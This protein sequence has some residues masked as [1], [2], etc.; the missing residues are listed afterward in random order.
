MIE[1]RHIGLRGEVQGVGYRYFAQREATA[2]GVAG[3]IRNRLDESV[4]IEA[5]AEPDALNRFEAAMRHGPGLAYVSS[6]EVRPMQP[7]PNAAGF[8]IVH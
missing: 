5:Q 1:R 3:W 4:E 8:Q 2:L 7:V 6:A